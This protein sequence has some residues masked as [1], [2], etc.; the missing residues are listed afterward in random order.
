MSTDTGH[1]TT[2]YAVQFYLQ[3]LLSVREQHAACQF[4]KA[5]TVCSFT[6]VDV[7]SRQGIFF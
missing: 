3:Y 1:F 4:P 7:Y 6:Q 5:R 2:G